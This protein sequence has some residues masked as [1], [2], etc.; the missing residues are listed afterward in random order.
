MNDHGLKRYLGIDIGGTAIKY[1]WGN[2]QKGIEVF[3]TVV[4]PKSGKAAMRQA[5]AD[6]IGRCE[7]ETGQ[8]SGIGIGIP[9]TLQSQSG[10]LMGINPN[11]PYLSETSVSELLPGNLAIPYWF[12]N[13]ANLMAYCEA[14]Q[15]PQARIVIGLTLG[16][17]IGG[18]AVIN[19]EIYRGACGFALEA[20]HIKVVDNGLDCNC[21]R[22]GCLEAYSSMNGMRN[23]LQ[24]MGIAAGDWDYSKMLACAT[25]DE[26]VNRVVNEGVNFLITGIE[27]ITVIIDPDMII[28]G[29]GMS[30]V[31]DFPWEMIRQQVFERIPIQN[32]NHLH[33]AKAAMGNRSGV[34]GGILW[35]EK[36]L[37]KI[38]VPF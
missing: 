15:Y 29:G 24:S 14:S 3:A 23:R 21:G 7:S 22:K 33:L 32:R 34:W 27:I 9:G 13:D 28:I 1:G 20:G 8:I 37:P 18:G 5:L 10:I 31:S 26:S 4:T 38:E 19:N 12:E 16:S 11:L 25:Y 35:A 6:I 2:R 30:E 17:G 36:M